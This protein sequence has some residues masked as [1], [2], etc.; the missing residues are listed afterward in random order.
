MLINA[1]KLK[2]KI[3][4]NHELKIND[5]NKKKKNK[6][7]RIKKKFKNIK[8]KNDFN[9]HNNNE[10]KKEKKFNKKSVNIKRFRNDNT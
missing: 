2:K 7:T 6:M 3:K 10:K 5:V 4:F 8:F 1:E 9:V